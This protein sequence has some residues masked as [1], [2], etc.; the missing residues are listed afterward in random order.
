M[1]DRQYNQL[2]MLSLSFHKVLLRTLLVALTTRMVNDLQGQGH[3]V[4]DDCQGLSTLSHWLRATIHPFLLFNLKALNNALQTVYTFIAFYSLV[5][6]LRKFGVQNC[7]K[8]W[9]S[10]SSKTG[11]D[12]QKDS[13]NVRKRMCLVSTVYQP[14]TWRP[15]YSYLQYWKIGSRLLLEANFR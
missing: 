1:N 3:R 8:P 5:T 10:L 15:N 4:L 11:H 7:F 2:Q 12:L 6:E 14:F 9:C 13:P